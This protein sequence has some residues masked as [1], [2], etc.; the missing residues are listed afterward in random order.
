MLGDFL[1]KCL[2][3]STYL[4]RKSLLRRNL[5][6]GSSSMLYYKSKIINLSKNKNN[7]T[8]GNHTHIKG[9]LL[10]YPETGKITIGNYC[11]IGEDSKLWSAEHIKIGNNV[12]ISHQVNIHDNNAHPIDFNDRKK[13]FEQ[14]ITVGHKPQPNLNGKEIIIEDDVWI[15]FNATVLKGVTIGK[16]AIVAACSVVTKDVPPFTMIAGNPA[17]II[18]KL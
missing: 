6:I 5:N 16:G 18:K 13:H 4:I 14:I 12:L 2:F 15:G 3:S 11:F 9:E 1:K 10:V 8:I 17:K 7:I